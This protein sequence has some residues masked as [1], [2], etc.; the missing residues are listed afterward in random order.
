MY[1]NYFYYNNI[2]ILK[3]IKYS[4]IILKNILYYYIDNNIITL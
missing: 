3:N 1:I 4:L 2:N